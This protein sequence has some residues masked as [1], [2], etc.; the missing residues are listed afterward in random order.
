MIVN[1][2][3]RHSILDAARLGDPDAD[4]IAIASLELA[5]GFLMVEHT[6]PLAILYDNRLAHVVVFVCAWRVGPRQAK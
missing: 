4:E 3:P 1:H 2:R 6:Q 5:L